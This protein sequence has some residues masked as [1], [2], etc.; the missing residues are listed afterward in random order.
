M[1][2]LGMPLEF[3]ILFSSVLVY[4]A[5]TPVTLAF[6]TPYSLWNGSRTVCDWK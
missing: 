5:L 3:V 1:L 2:Q 6:R 4:V